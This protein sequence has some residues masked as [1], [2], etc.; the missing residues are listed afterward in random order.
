MDGR[1]V[2]DGGTIPAVGVA[3]GRRTAC[4][5]SSVLGRLFST[6]RRGRNAARLT[7]ISRRVRAERLTYL[8]PQRLRT[9]E[10]CA[11]TV[12]RRGVAG[13]FV[14]A[15]I[16]LGGS[17][18]VLASHMG[19]GRRFHG[20][21]VFGM[22][23]PPGDDDPPEAHER[24]GVIASGSSGGIGGDRYYGYV[25]DLLEQV[26]ANFARFDV[27]VDGNRVQLHV[28]LFDDTMHP[29]GPVALA[30]VDSD[31]YDPVRTCL[32]RLA[33][34]LAVGG[35]IVLDDYF[36]YGGCRRAVDEFLA[37]RSDFVIETRAANVAIERRA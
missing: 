17:A 37:E 20:Y 5:D 7:P 18:I 36:D 30:H 15:G 27:P 35:R 1:D 24:Y 8:S 2:D 25:D 23:P 21:D 33:P 12:N 29:Q 19:P 10:D 9:L 13:D 11:R 34:N 22:I 3:T 4:L 26:T 32:E 14:E 6:W 16:A 28:G 31:W